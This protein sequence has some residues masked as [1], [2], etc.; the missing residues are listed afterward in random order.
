LLSGGVIG[1]KGTGSTAAVAQVPNQPSAQSPAPSAPAK[2]DVSL[3]HL[4]PKGQA[5]AKVAVVE[6]A[7]M[8][9]PFCERFFTDTEPQLLKEYVD[10]GKV[11]FA[12]RHYEFLG[13]ASIT[14]GNAVECANAQGKFWEM[15]DYLY[16]NQPDESDTTMYVSDKLTTIA[17]TLGVTSSTF[18][19]CLDSTQFT[20]NLTADQN[21]GSTAGV[22]ATPSFVIGKLDSSGTKIVGGQLVVGAVPYTMIKTAIDQALTD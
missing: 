20:N 11:K 1:A 10:T 3:G 19:Q 15:Y 18:K 5:N 9:C 7:D 8:R 17:T 13:P 2:V 14:A 16:K 6:F 4:P 22:Q 12:F 21:D